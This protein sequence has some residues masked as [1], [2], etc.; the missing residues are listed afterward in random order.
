MEYEEKGE[1]NSGNAVGKC[2]EVSMHR[3]YMK[4]RAKASLLEWINIFE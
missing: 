1:D 2:A 4:E 3:T